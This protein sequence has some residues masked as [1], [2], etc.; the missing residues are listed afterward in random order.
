MRLVLGPALLLILGLPASSY[1]APPNLPQSPSMNAGQS[2]FRFRDAYLLESKIL[3]K[4]ETYDPNHSEA[5]ISRMDPGL[6]NPQA[7][8]YSQ[9]RDD[10]TTYRD[11]TWV[12][13]MEDS[14][15]YRQMGGL[16]LAEKQYIE[17]LTMLR[18]EQG[19]SSSDV[20]YMLDHLGEFYLE[21]R[22][23][24]EAYKTFS[25]ALEVRRSSLDTFTC[26]VVP[27][28]V[29]VASSR[30][31]RACRLHLSDLLTRLGQLDIG[32]G[33]LASANKKLSEAVAIVNEKDNLGDNNGLY[34]IYFRSLALEQQSNWR[35]AEDLWK[36]AVKLRE[37]MSGSANYWDAQKEMAA[38]YARHGDFRSAAEIASR[39]QVETAGKLQWLMPG[40]TQLLD[41]RPRYE[42][43]S[44]YAAESNTAMNEILAVDAWQTKGPEAAAALLQDPIYAPFIF[45]R[46]SDSERTQLLAWFANRIYL[47]MSILLDGN[48]SQDRI[49]EAYTLLSKIKGR[50]LAF[51]SDVT[52]SVEVQRSNPNTEIPEF[53]MLDQLAVVRA[54]Q[55]H[56]FLRA[57]LDG[58]KLNQAQFL[59]NENTQRILST[60]VVSGS[61]ALS[62]GSDFSIKTLQRSVPDDAAFIDII[63]WQR[64]DRDSSEPPHRE[65]GA[66]VIRH[67]QPVR[68]LRLGNVDSID[69]DIDRVT[70]GV[71]ARG[72]SQRGFSSNGQELI[73]SAQLQ[74]LLRGLYQKVIA[75][76]EP[77]LQGASKLYISPDGKLTVAP[78]SAFVDAKGNY[79]LESRA[80]T[81]VGS[82]GDMMATQVFHSSKSS[83]PLIVGD[84]AF[85]I[86]LQNPSMPVSP[87]RLN[88][89]AIGGLVD[90]PNAAKEAEAV[91]K[92]LGVSP[93]RVLVG[94]DALKNT[95]ESAQSP[96]ILHIATH[97]IARFDWKPPVSIYSVFEFPQQWDTQYPLLLSMIAFAGADARQTN[98]QDGMMTGLEVSSL[99][100]IG[101]K[102]V[103]LSSCESG[104]GTLLDAQGVL[105]L[106]AAFSMAGAETL[107]TTLWP[108]GD[109][110]ELQF[111]KFFYSHR[112]EDPAEAVRL[113]QRE[114]SKTDRFSS[115]KYWAGYAASGSLV[116]EQA[117]RLDSSRGSAH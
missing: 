22:K 44:Q 39:V 114:M 43:S 45:K 54:S 42:T 85:N 103:V 29:T 9:Q 28:R 8:Q 96:E 72:K 104:N 91:R 53:S 2:P 84:P 20:A 26:P 21:E 71:G 16:E 41:N 30:S 27:R 57:A 35:E 92:I 12:S 116:R 107:V 94:R 7:R 24:D 55:A 25:E 60:A 102:L 111:M 37:S 78:I 1:A 18:K 67:N 101:S 40:S 97:S 109:E 15:R 23:F 90:L 93:D 69:A 70:R 113:A 75:P 19:P 46:G 50:Y 38:F 10:P 100:L 17:I 47:H 105:G 89:R 99:H 64:R 14:D 13:Y 82:W 79:L 86:N 36:E 59:A 61:M 5:W 51:I 95:I 117:N 81:Y 11:A 115:P 98:S 3:S 34:A 31:L 106:R 48:P 52:R 110:A 108:V 65:Y 63:A 87:S 83:A 77:S 68:Y 62:T 66:F 73:T 58:E 74:S 4:R 112:A 88:L 33:D 76:L 49:D 32:K 80:I 56:L 6:A